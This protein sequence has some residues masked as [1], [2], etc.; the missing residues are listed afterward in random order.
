MKPRFAYDAYIFKFKKLSGQSWIDQWKHN[1]RMLGLIGRKWK[2]REKK[3]VC[4]Q[5]YC[6]REGINFKCYLT[7]LH[8]CCNLSSCIRHND[9]SKG[10]TCVVIPVWT[11]VILGSLWFVVDAVGNVVGE[12]IAQ[13][14]AP[15]SHTTFMPD[16]MSYSIYFKNIFPKCQHTGCGTTYQRKA[17]WLPPCW[18]LER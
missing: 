10:R 4:R 7:S 12:D 15:I 1:H 13:L 3:K 8:E 9:A 6:I 14:L 11:H 5:L 17:N 18:Y 2:T 16:L